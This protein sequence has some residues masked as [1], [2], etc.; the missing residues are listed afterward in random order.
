MKSLGVS[1]LFE[2]PVLFFKAITNKIENKNE[3]DGALS[4]ASIFIYGIIF[5]G[6]E[7]DLPK[8]IISLSLVLPLI[9]I[10]KTSKFLQRS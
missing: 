9:F 5:A 4:I 1:S 8:Y 6:L 2:L 10:W 7:G 3:A